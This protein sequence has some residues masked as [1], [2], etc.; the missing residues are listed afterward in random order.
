M[1][2]VYS[3]SETRARAQGNRFRQFPTLSK[4]RARFLPYAR[5][6][7]KGPQVPADARFF[8]I[9]ACF[10][11]SIERELK[12]AGREVL[13]SPTGLGLP[14]SMTEQFLRYNIFNLDVAFNELNW[15]L[16]SGSA[17]ADKALLPLGETLADTQI[18]W[19][20]AHQP[21]LAHEFRRIYN[22]SYSAIVDA[23]VVILATGG[24]E[25]WYDNDQGIYINSMPG[26]VADNAFPGRFDLHR[27][28]VE[29]AKSTLEKTIKLIR[30]HSKRDPI[31][32]I[33]VS[34][35]SQPMIFGPDDVLVDQFYSKAVQRLAVEDV[36]SQDAKCHYLPALE[37]A[38]WSDFSY[39]YL[40]NSMNHTH[41]NFAARVV[42]DMLEASGADDLTFKEHKA[43][44]H[45]IALMSGGGSSAALALCEEAFDAGSRQDAELDSLYIRGLLKAHRRDDAFQ[46]AMTRLEA[47]INIPQMMR[48]ALST[49]NRVISS[50]QVVRLTE[51]AKENDL[52]VEPIA[53][54][55]VKGAGA[56][57][58]NARAMLNTIAEVMA[59][60]DHET[61]IRLANEMLDAGVEL[62]VRDQARLH[63][64]LIRALV[65]V[66]RVDEAV[67]IALA[68]MDTQIVDEPAGFAAADGVLRHHARGADL[69][70]LLPRLRKRIPSEKLVGLEKVLK[71]RLGI[72]S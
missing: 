39:N 21:D 69:E 7:V 9:G 48:L 11:R 16:S 50:E 15:A 71:K 64:M 57:A 60:R 14:G 40:E 55:K 67:A 35:V 8:A 3:Y 36:V 33:A 20:F 6:A 1:A 2:E 27:I 51:I 59:S 63:Q 28:G 45:G 47:G 29:D 17:G 19:T 5:P 65:A 68:I 52:P 26:P 61:V 23:D 72:R 31:F 46:H 12:F 49:G 4:G 54:L 56:E 53:A 42:S 30:D 24:I 22:G 25:Q 38:M 37:A 10:P 41:P 13:S 66:E 34:P 58:Q 43:K 62:Q 18:G 44:S 70:A 32:Y